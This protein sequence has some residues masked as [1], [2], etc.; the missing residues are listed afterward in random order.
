MYDLLLSKDLVAF[1]WNNGA[2]EAFAAAV[3]GNTQQRINVTGG[4]LIVLNT[5]QGAGLY[6]I[7]KNDAAGDA[8]GD[9]AQ[10]FEPVAGFEQAFRAPGRLV[11]DVPAHRQHIYVDGDRIE[12]RFLRDDGRIIERAGTL[13]LAPSAG[14]RL[15]I[16]YQ[17]GYVRV[18]RSTPEDQARDKIQPHNLPPFADLPLEA[19][20]DGVGV[21][22]DAPQRW[23]ITLAE[24]QYVV[25]E[26]D[27]PGMMALVA[28]NQVLAS[29]IGSRAAGHHLRYF[30]PAGKYALWT[31]PLQ[32]V[33]Q[34]GAIR[35][36]A[37]TPYDLDG[38]MLKSWLIAP[39]ETQV[40]RFD[41]ATESTVG[42]GVETES[43]R[44]WAELRDEAFTLLASGPLMLE[45]LDAGTYLCIVRP[46][47]DGAA[48]VRYRPV[49]YGHTGSD[50]GI[51]DDVVKEYQQFTSE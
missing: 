48:P 40:F 28:D 18:W 13:E 46:N 34:Q 22:Q 50:Q 41:V 15:E 33:A 45:K 4:H 1:A 31:R 37:V 11:L 43:D 38:A 39:G 7:E 27:A 16:D 12:S 24:P 17:S 23:R 14:G 19:C 25:I 35:M 21:L 10:P 9:T 42:V 8:A 49:V 26:A 51:P 20:D 36:Q 29:S 3:D 6:R 5:G 2:A 32:G 44:L 30:L 47:A